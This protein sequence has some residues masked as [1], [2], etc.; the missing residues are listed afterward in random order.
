MV[1]VVGV[2]AALGEGDF[3]GVANGEL[4]GGCVGD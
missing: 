1:V 3:F 2:G 4:A